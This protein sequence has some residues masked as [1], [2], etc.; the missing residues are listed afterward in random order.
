MAYKILTNEEFNKD[1]KLN[2]F[3]NNNNKD[4]Q[5]FENIIYKNY[6]EKYNKI[7]MNIK[8]RIGKNGITLFEKEICLQKAHNKDILKILYLTTNEKDEN[9]CKLFEFNK[10][11]NNNENNNIF[12]DNKENENN[13]EIILSLIVPE[14]FERKI[15]T[16]DSRINLNIYRNFVLKIDL[17]EKKIIDK[18]LINIKKIDINNL[19]QVFKFDEK[20]KIIEINN[21]NETF[22][23]EENE[24]EMKKFFKNFENKEKLNDAQIKSIKEFIETT[25][26]K[27]NKFIEQI[28]KLIFFINNL[29]DNFK[30]D[31]ILNE[32]ITEIKKK[33]SS[34]VFKE[35]FLNFFNINKLYINNI[36]N[37][38]DLIEDIYFKNLLGNIKQNFNTK[39]D[40][41][42]DIKYIF[43]DNKI[44]T[45]EIFVKSLKRIIFRFLNDLNEEDNIFDIYDN[46][47]YLLDEYNE[48][49]YFEIKKGFD[50]KL[51]AKNCLNIYKNL[52]NEIIVLK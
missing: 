47:L 6:A 24:N 25:N 22:K 41:I 7:L 10:N 49:E 39:D 21:I 4:S 11:N 28:F 48:N 15:I 18:Y 46:N 16:T 30:D 3:I 23:I 43:K 50:N 29:T 5:N 44:I 12:I 26:L 17:L 42:N 33:E 52:N 31:T 9:I 38:I 13:N 40:N 2:F 32:V 36:F 45:K 35:E 14:F 1:C 20:E 37:L 19:M 51:L 27:P 8:K 34:K